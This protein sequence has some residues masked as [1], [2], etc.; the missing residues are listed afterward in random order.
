MTNDFFSNRMLFRQRF[1]ATL[2]SLFAGLLAPQAFPQSI[3]DVTLNVYKDE[4]CGCCVGWI[5]HMS[6]HNYVSTVFHPSNLNAVKEEL[7]VKRQWQSCHTAVTADGYVFEGHIP[8]KFISQFL[9]D[10]PD[11]AL[12]LA[13]PGMPLGGPGMEMGNRFTPYDILLMNKDGSSRVYASI[14]SPADQ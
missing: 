12:G 5:E 2:L 4:S 1:F 13:V 8:A 11:G 9:A 7:G 6:Q 10:P 3:D 14:K